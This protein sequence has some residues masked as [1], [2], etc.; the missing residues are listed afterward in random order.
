MMASMRSP[1]AVSRLAAFTIALLLLLQE[2]EPGWGIDGAWE[3]YLA[4]F[5]LTLVTAFTWS[6]S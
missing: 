5:L 1:L 3:W 2:V 6:A 4:L